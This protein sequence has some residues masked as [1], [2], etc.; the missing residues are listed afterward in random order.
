MSPIFMRYFTLV[1]LALAAFTLQLKAPP[2]PWEPP[3]Q[4]APRPPHAGA[5]S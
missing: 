3:V 1:V 2:A 4:T 5:T